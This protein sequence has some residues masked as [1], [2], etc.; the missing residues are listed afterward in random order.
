[1]QK[2]ITNFNGPAS[3]FRSA[4][5]LPDSSKR[6]PIGVEIATD[7]NLSLHEHPIIG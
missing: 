6:P 7:K 4:S 3:G 2:E 5:A 1:L